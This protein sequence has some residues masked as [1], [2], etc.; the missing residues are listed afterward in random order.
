VRHLARRVLVAVPA[1]L[2]TPL[3]HDLPDWKVQA[4][5]TA[6]T[7]GSTT[8]VVAADVSGPEEHRDWAFVTTVG[9]RFDCIINPAPGPQTFRDCA[10]GEEIV[11][12]V[13]YGNRA[14]Y[15]PDLVEDPQAAREWLEDFLHRGPCPPRPDPR[16]PPADLGT[17]LRR[18]ESGPRGRGARAAQEGRFA[19]LR[20][21][22]DVR[23]RRDPRC[24]R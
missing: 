21:G 10:R 18:V 13:C 9:A 19:A 6:Q 17:L 5:S 8:M 22:L 16:G 23:E 14:G 7:P 2:V 3:V 15:R 20:R 11:H 1:P 12:F 4:L 24:A